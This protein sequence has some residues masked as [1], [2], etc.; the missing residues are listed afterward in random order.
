M[1][2]TE[3][4]FARDRQDSS[5]TYDPILKERNTKDGKQTKNYLY[6]L[7]LCLKSFLTVPFFFL[8]LQLIGHIKVSW[9]FKKL[10]TFMGKH[11]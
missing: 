5:S 4:S 6:N 10:K 8:T 11:K 3:R 9:I 2:T 7:N 1:G